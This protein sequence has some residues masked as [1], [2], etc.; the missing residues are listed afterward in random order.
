MA[1]R[2]LWT[3]EL[4]ATRV[5]VCLCVCTEALVTGTVTSVRARV[6]APDAPNTPDLEASRQSL[7]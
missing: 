6:L 4:V 3:V 1:V 7:A 2:N 5:C